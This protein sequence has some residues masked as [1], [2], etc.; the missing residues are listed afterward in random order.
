MGVGSLA[1]AGQW[2]NKRLV[3]ELVVTATQRRADVRVHSRT[4]S[5][6]PGH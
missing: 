1:T 5:L 2:G 4:V 6:A 3:R